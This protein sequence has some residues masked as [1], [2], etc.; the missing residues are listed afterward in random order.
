MTMARLVVGGWAAVVG[1][2]CAAGCSSSD[3]EGETAPTYYGDVAPI[4]SEYCVNCH[5]TGGVAPFALETYEQAVTVAPRVALA[6]RE[7]VMP[8]WLADASGACGDFHDA[9]WLSE[10]Q[11]DTI[12]AW[13]EAGTPEGDA[14]LEVPAPPELPTVES[15][16]AVLDMGVDYAPG[17][18]ADDDYRCFVIDPGFEEDTFVTGYEVVPG[19]PQ[20][21]HHVIIY[22]LREEE[23]EAELDALDAADEGPGYTCF[24]SSGLA[25]PPAVLWAPG[26]GATRFP[27]G[28]GIRI[29]ANRR[30]V[31]QVHY[32]VAGG[33]GLDRTTVK[34]ETDPD[35]DVE[36]FWFPVADWDMEVPARTEN[37]MTSAVEP[38]D[39]SPSGRLRIYGA[40]PH[41]HTLGR[42]MTVE[43][44]R[45]DGT[46]ECLAHL[47]RWDFNWQRAYWY[48]TPITVR[49][50]DSLRISCSY[51]TT[52]R[53]EP[54]AWGDGTQDEM[55]L[56]F[57][58]VSL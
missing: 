44:E 31:M 47:P 26:I 5:Q 57:F 19:D 10:E 34:L 40:A 36:A 50:G 24:G 25:A 3:D 37:A 42:Q 2:L 33:G 43:L 14:S 38:M 56:N 55:C 4:L 11:I 32:N 35:A 20:I 1:L 30:V 6:T 9:Q 58:Y 54:V 7:R 39:W 48:T 15:P 49:N 27:E 53:S 29:P 21:V 28:T 51:D 46:P 12:G 45:A 41:M 23:Q 22:Y 52:T 8:P 16:D 13:V 17:T 18:T